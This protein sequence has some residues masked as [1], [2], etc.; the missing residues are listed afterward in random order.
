[1]LSPRTIS[2]AL[3]ALSLGFGAASAQELTP[4]TYWPAPKG[5]KVGVLGSIGLALLIFTVIAYFLK[6]EYWRDV[7]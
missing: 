2:A 3:L 6:K 1:M 7:H 5:V 4:R